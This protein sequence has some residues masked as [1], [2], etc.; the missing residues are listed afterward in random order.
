VIASGGFADGA[1]LAAAL[2]LGASGANFGTRFIATP[3]ANVSDAYKRAVLAA[4]IGDTRTVGRDIGMIRTLHNEF[5]DDME[6]LEGSGAALDERKAVFTASTLK[7][8]AFDGNVAR[9]KL[10]AGQSVGLVGDIVP[11][12]ELVRR[13]AREYGDVI[14]TL[15]A[16]AQ[17]A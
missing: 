12:G 9:G 2:A 7:D 4:G 6:R 3:E 10:E 1:G 15:P 17:S 5:T 16:L 8:A 14:G 13:I 11:A